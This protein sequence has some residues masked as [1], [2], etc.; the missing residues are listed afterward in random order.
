M[1]KKS[2]LFLHCKE[3]RIEGHISKEKDAPTF[4]VDI[5]GSTSKLLK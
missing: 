3:L 4:D 5:F 2:F 1:K